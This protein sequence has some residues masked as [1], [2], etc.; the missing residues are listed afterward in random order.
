MSP[1]GSSRAVRPRR[2]CTPKVVDVSVDVDGE[3][4]VIRPIGAS[5]LDAGVTQDWILIA[6]DGAGLTWRRRRERDVVLPFGGWRLPPD[7]CRGAD[8]VGEVRRALKLGGL[9]VAAPANPE[10]PAEGD[11]FPRAWVVRRRLPR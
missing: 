5:E 6:L 4:V 2:L 7:P 1:A 9:E 10:I 3:L 11:D 8:A